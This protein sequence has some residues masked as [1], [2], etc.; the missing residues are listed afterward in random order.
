MCVPMQD[1]ASITVDVSV[2]A[3]SY[4]EDEKTNG[5]SHFLEHM[6][7]KGTIN[8]PH[9]GQIA[10]ELD[11]IGA[12]ANASTGTEAT[13]YYV[14]ARPQHLAH[15]LELVSDIYLNSTF[16]ETEIEKEKGVVCDEI[17]MYED[18]P[19]SVASHMLRTTMYG[20]TIYGRDIAGTKENVRS[21]TRDAI[22]AY[23]K[24]HYIA[25]KTVITVAGNIEVEEVVKHVASLFKN[26]PTGRII[27]LPLRSSRLESP[28]SV[29]KERDTEQTHVRIG[30]KGLP[31]QHKDRYALSILATILGGSMS[32][33]LFI[34]LRE[35]MGVSYYCGSTHRSFATGGTFVI[36][37]GVSSHKVHDACTA[38][39]DE[40]IRLAKEMVTKEELAKVKEMYTAGILM[41]LETS[42]AMAE[43]VSTF[44]FNGEPVLTPAQ[45]E[46]K[47]RSV[48]PEDILRVAR[49]LFTDKY[50]VVTVGKR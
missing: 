34:R 50:Y 39:R 37:T 36:Y 42:G 44:V 32:S 38:I 40:C 25:E 31:R 43:Y 17:A 11:E 27:H 2:H 46:R 7:F 9:P 48:T 4:Y 35:T 45:L 24:K 8:R 29:H 30:Y 6:C 18:D 41:D 49:G 14:K 47:Y 15:V 1:S 20:N 26:I 28:A 19:Q 12:Y 3:G 16:P 13:S 10:R 22:C 23:R 21:F 5:V 33:R